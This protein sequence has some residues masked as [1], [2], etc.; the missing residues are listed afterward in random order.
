[1]SQAD[2]PLQPDG[3]PAEDGVKA[4]GGT[5]PPTVVLGE[6]ERRLGAVEDALERLEEGSYGRCRTCGERVEAERLADDPLV[7]TCGRCERARAAAPAA[8]AAGVF[9]APRAAEAD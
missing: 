8:G 2:T 1:M 7:V 5:P 6:L 4:T 3:P 9:G